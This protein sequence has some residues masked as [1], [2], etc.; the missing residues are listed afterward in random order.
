[1]V[2]R[3]AGTPAATSPGS[4][5]ASPAGTPAMR[6]PSPTVPTTPTPTA[7][8]ASS[9]TAPEALPAFSH[10]WVIVME[11]H[12]LE[13]VL[14]SD[15]VQYIDSLIARYGLAEQYHAVARPSQPNYLALFSGSTHGVTDNDAH[16]ITAP[17]I[18][19]QLEASGRTWRAY[20]EN[21]PPGCFT[22]ATATDGR[23]GPGEYA[24]KHAPAIS[25]TSISGDPRRC[26][27]I[28]DF[29][30]FDPAASDFAF[31]TP[32]LCHDAHDCSLGDADDWLATF[33]PRILDS[34]AYQDGGV[35]FLT[36]DESEGNVPA[37]GQVATI[38]ISPDVARGLHS[39]VPHD[40]Y[41][42]LRTIQDAWDLGCLANS[43]AANTLS[44][45]FP[46]S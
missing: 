24:R 29:S 46:P 20:A 35:V 14:G 2:A 31:I 7:S 12:G 32:N 3:P 26:A 40:H 37:G 5:G 19:D 30:A 6:L 43:C 4:T 39:T 15:R 13:R 11:N 44:E 28:T 10:V 34:P 17:T 22:G 36:F 42:L 8:V 41:S 18:A 45:F 1:M 23:D 25:F 27:N 16:D 21:V 33:L 38:V 9:P